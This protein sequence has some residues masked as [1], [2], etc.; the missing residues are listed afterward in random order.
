MRVSF[1]PN[2]RAALWPC[3][4][5]RETMLELIAGVDLLLLGNEEARLLFGTDEPQD[6]F[7]RVTDRCIGRTVLKCCARSAFAL[8]DAGRVIHAMPGT[9]DP[10]DP[11]G[12]G[13]A[14]DAGL[15]VGLLRGEDISAAM[16]L[17]GR[18]GALTVSR[19]GE[20]VSFTSDLLAANPPR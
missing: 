10:I 14:F 2:Y 4:E 18:C 16:E 11:V 1:E 9:V 19:V 12:A 5:A 6:V 20:N 15:V 8:S 17:A 13:D 7:R 3:D